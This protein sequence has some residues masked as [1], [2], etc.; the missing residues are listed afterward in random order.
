[1]FEFSGVGSASMRCMGGGSFEFIFS[2]AV[3]TL[4]SMLGIAMSVRGASI[5]SGSSPGGSC[6]FLQV[7]PATSGSDC[8]AF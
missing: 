1:M 7:V 6:D 5:R 4:P 8:D 3:V 2:V